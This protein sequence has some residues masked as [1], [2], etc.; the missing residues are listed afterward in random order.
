MAI[1]IFINQ[2]NTEMKTVFNA[3][4]NTLTMAKIGKH[5]DAFG[6]SKNALI[7]LAVSNYLLQIEQRERPGNN[8]KLTALK[9]G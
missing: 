3:R 7:N 2:K 6:I 4:F 1:E 5:S 8:N 9:K